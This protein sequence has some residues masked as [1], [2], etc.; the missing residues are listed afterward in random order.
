MRPPLKKRN[1]A[2][3][4]PAAT[5]S[6]TEALQEK[7]ALAK[8]LHEQGVNPVRWTEAHP[9]PQSEQATFQQTGIKPRGNQFEVAGKLYNWSD[10]VKATPAQAK[11]IGD[12]YIAERTGKDDAVAVVPKIEELVDI[13]QVPLKHP[14]GTPHTERPANDMRV[15]EERAALIKH[16]AQSGVDPDKAHLGDPVEMKQQGPLKAQIEKILPGD[17]SE[18]SGLSGFYQG[19]DDGMIYQANAYTRESEVAQKNGNE[20]VAANENVDNGEL[21]KKFNEAAASQLAAAA[22]QIDGIVSAIEHSQANSQLTESDRAALKPVEIAFAELGYK[23][24][25]KKAQL[26]YLRTVANAIKRT[27]SGDLAAKRRVPLHVL[28]QEQN[29]QL[30]QALAG[31]TV[32]AMALRSLNPVQVLAAAVKRPDKLNLA[33]QV[34]MPVVLAYAAGKTAAEIAK[35]RAQ[36]EGAPKLFSPYADSPGALGR[37]EAQAMPAMPSSEDIL[38]ELSPADVEQIDRVF[39]SQPSTFNRADPRPMSPTQKADMLTTG[40]ISEIELFGL[41][42]YLTDPRGSL[43]TQERIDKLKQMVRDK[44]I[45]CGMTEEQAWGGEVAQNA[46]ERAKERFVPRGEDGV[47][48]SR[49]ADLSFK[50]TWFGRTYIIDINTVDVLKSGSMTKAERIAAEALRL[51]RLIRL[52]INETLPDNQKLDEFE[53]KIGTVPK[54][55]DMTDEEWE[56]AAKDWVDS[57]LDCDGPLEAD[58]YLD[59]ESKHPWPG[60]E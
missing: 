15:A 57:F 50:V 29:V 17:K 16:Y 14:L 5:D 1:E 10:E 32:A 31:E 49:R 6:R 13:A 46:T 59:P 28:A 42:I 34:V 39:S 54:G 22:T 56:A 43:Q 37:E 33:A 36:E 19:F 48:G 38:K 58:V 11:A 30:T 18:I 40:T 55:K 24:D 9:A 12:A 45:E 20:H 8:H 26:D 53:G 2:Q 7:A 27:A 23:F 51:N 60:K 52:S 4:V 47:K 35:D 3:A 21:E 25:P 41:P 44:L